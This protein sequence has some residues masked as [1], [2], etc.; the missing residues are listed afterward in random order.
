M[1]RVTQG[2]SRV[3][4]AEDSNIRNHHSVDFGN[5]RFGHSLERSPKYWCAA[6]IYVIRFSANQIGLFEASKNTTKNQS[7]KMFQTNVTDMSKI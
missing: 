4:N 1:S 2:P 6:K 3:K 7:E 5:Y